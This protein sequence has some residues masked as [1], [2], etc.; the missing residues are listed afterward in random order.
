MAKY[1]C[2]VERHPAGTYGGFCATLPVFVAGKDSLEEAQRALEEG[3][4]FYLAHLKAEGLPV[5]EAGNP[6]VEEV[7]KDFK[8]EVRANLTPVWVGVK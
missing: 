7:L 4:A 8:E 6:A 2:F 1:L 3:V 5:P